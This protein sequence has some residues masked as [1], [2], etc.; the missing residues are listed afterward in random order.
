MAYGNTNSLSNAYLD[1]AAGTVDDW[2]K[3]DMGVIDLFSSHSPFWAII[4]DNSLQPGGDFQLRELPLDGGIDWR[5][6][7]FGRGLQSNAPAGVTRAN[8][9]N[10]LTPAIPSD[11]TNPRWLRSTYRGMLT[12]DYIRRTTNT[13]KAAMVDIASMMVNQ[14]KADFFDQYETDIWDN[15]A[16]SE[17][18]VQS[19]NAAL[20]NTGSVAGIDQ[21]DTANNSWWI[22]V[23]DTTSEMT[24]LATHRR[25]YDQ[26]TI[27]TSVPTGVGRGSPDIAFYYG[28][29]FTVIREEIEQAQRLTYGELTKGGFKFFEH[30]GVRFFRNTRQVADTNIMLNSKTWVIRYVTKTPEAVTETFIPDPNRPGIWTKGYIHTISLGC[31][32]I[33]HNVLMTN[34]RATP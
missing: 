29:N 34:K 9:V 18:K 5:V 3:T 11:L 2:L 22:A 26:A 17:S 24:N 14:I 7:V 1:L 19:V 21:T 16:G 28:D 20:A 4:L 31:L 27:D 10:A 8:L 13:G 12:D 25:M 6:P 15:A 30:N 33:K 32:S 23:Q